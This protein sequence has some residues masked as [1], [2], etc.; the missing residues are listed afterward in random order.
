MEPLL[1]P[2][3]H[4]L[5]REKLKSMGAGA[6]TDEE[7]LSVILGSGSRGCPV[8]SIAERLLPTLDLG[9][10]PVD[11]DALRQVKPKLSPRYVNSI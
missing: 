10:Y 11:V 3:V 1:E 7:L 6:L 4:L 8:H 2:S 9:G 5:P